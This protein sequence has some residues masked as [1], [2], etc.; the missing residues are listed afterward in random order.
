MDKLFYTNV[1]R[2]GDDILLRGINNGESFS[3]RVKFNPTLFVP[4][5]K[6]TKYKTLDG[7]SVSPVHPG[8]MR[9]CREFIQKYTG[10][11]GFDVYGNTDYIYQFIGKIHPGE[12]E[13]DFNQ[14][15]IAYIDIETTCELGFPNVDDPQEEIN[16]ITMI[17]GK[18]QYVLGL[19]EFDDIDGAE[20]HRF[21]REEDLIDKFL[22]IW[23]HECPDIVSG[24]NVRFFDIPYLYSRISSVRGT[25]QA[26]RMSPWR[27]VQEK[28]IN[29]MNREQTAYDLV[30]ISTLDYY[31]LYLTFT[32]TNQESY[33]LD[34]IANIELGES[35]LS[36]DEF[37]NMAEFYK[38][39]FDKFV[40]YNHKDTELIVRLEEKMKLMELAVALAYSA[41][42]NFVDVYSQ[43]RTWD[44]IIYHY[45]SEQNIVIPMKSGSKKDEQY[46]GAYVK[47]PIVGRHEWVVSFDLNS[48]YP[49]LIMQYNISPETK[50]Q[51][52]KDR[53][54]TP[55]SILRG[56]IPTE[57]KH[58]L[59]ANGTCYTKD[60]QGFLPA[61][62][63]KM[64]KERKMYKKMMIEAEKRKQESPSDRSIDFEISKYHNF[65]QVRKIQLN[66][67]YGAI[68]NE[69]FRYFDVDMAEAITLSGQLSIRWIINY[70]NEF[71]NETLETTDIDYVVASDTDSVYLT[72]DGLVRKF[73]PDE[74]DKNKIVDYLDKAS[75][76][77][78]QPFIDEKYQELAELMN[79][80][81]NKMVMGRE[82]I[83][84]C[85][86][87]TAKKRYMLNVWD[88][89]GVRYKSPKLKI[90][91]I[92]T[93]RSSTPQ[94]VRDW[95]KKSISIILTG[96]E[97]EMIRFIDEKRREFNGL[98]VEDIA[99]PRGVSN[100]DKYRDHSGIYRKSTPIAV[101]GA[102]IYNHFVKENGLDRKY[103]LISDGEKVKFVMLKRQNP[104][105]GPKGDQVISFPN[106]LPVE[107]G[108]QKY[109]D[110]EKQFE[111]SFL[112]PL[113]SIL[114]IV[115]WRTEQVSTLE[116][117]FS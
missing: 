44:Q 86:I 15:K 97:T 100:L 88:S 13:Y 42:V 72:L 51:E 20:C 81:Q 99:F 16:A 25:S 23:E 58:S 38:K 67:A 110:Y 34:H 3:R 31:E 76:E 89:E 80:Y 37:E 105:A 90:M 32:Y 79:A 96:T 107:L 95:L 56:T 114:D 12:V 4:S 111:K 35:K 98:D 5:N 9:E 71:L 63:E 87:W 94:V 11:Q 82:V 52:E 1:S 54:I 55:D 69:W 2:R 61:L 49:H 8:T 36:Y 50:I 24:W 91:G 41:K 68:G 108:L 17:V 66:S 60:R 93:T 27:M 102:L 6:E 43:V 57:T 26:K 65:Q 45:L 7:T 19:G 115:R 40:R 29:R 21:F 75:E 83:A 47:D 46:A 92:E 10:I 33:R 62:M 14:L 113:T 39:D 85:G 116:G 103:N 73:L 70:L 48:L 53:S 106:R 78:L 59:A 104:I 22:D 84:D 112:D 101:K 18:N 64:Y 28:T 109:V 30:G 74:T 117:L 77:T